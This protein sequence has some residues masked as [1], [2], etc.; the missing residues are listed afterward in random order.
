MIIILPWVK[1][2]DSEYFLRFKSC[3]AGRSFIWALSLKDLHKHNKNPS[4]I[5]RCQDGGEGSGNS[6]INVMRQA[7]CYLHDR[8]ANEFII[9][10]DRTRAML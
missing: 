4:Y 3:D 7:D 5:W 10:S 1:G 6:M 8:Y 2:H 9:V